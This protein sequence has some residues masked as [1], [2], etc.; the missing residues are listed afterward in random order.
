MAKL[1]VGL[2]F[3]G[4]SV[5]HEVSL[6]SASSIARA[7]D[8]DRY[9]VV[10]IAIDHEGH[11]RLGAGPGLLAEAAQS[12]EEV[13]LPAVPGGVLLPEAR[14]ADASEGGGLGGGLVLD[15]VFPIVHGR[16]GEDGA[17]QGL[18][19]LADVAYVGSGVLSSAVQMD[20]D[21]ARRLLAAAG[22]PV[23]PDMVLR[24]A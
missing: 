4:R 13:R 7:L 3:G 9:E 10:Y 23:V 1:R 2:L 5:E 15:V 11:W 14:A 8:P 18:L 16:G 12:G 19:E 21:V 20:K 24:G 17:L 22:L 6:S